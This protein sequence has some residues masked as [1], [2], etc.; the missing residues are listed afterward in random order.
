LADIM[1]PLSS[2]NII[3]DFVEIPG[4]NNFPLCAK[5]DPGPFH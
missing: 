3:V 2:E 4:C 5:Q 1:P